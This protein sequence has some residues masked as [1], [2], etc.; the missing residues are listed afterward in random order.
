MLV[1]HGTEDI[2]Y[3]VLEQGGGVQGESVHDLLF[4]MAN[5]GVEGCLP[6][7]PILYSNQEVGV[8]EVNLVN[9]VAPWISSDLNKRRG[10]GSRFF[11]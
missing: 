4:V 8:A 2:D 7:V 6:L 1:E 11:A 3:L 9:M 10:S 5:W